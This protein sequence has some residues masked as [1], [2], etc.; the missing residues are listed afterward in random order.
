M[1]YRNGTYV[2]FHADGEKEPTESDMKYYRLLQAWNEQGDIDFQFV[3]SHEKTGAVRDSSKRATLRRSLV[4]RL[5]NSKNFL[6]LIGETTREDRDWVPFEISHAIDECGLPIIACYTV[7]RCP[8]A[9][10]SLLRQYW[11]AALDAR[12]ST[13]AAHVIHIPFRK[14]AILDA[15]SQFNFNKYPLGGGLGIYAAQTYASWNISFK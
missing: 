9:D 6:L 15:I 5:H 13:G 12:I 4:T 10:A 11:P 1:A 7:L 2:A 8:I 14:E 3:N